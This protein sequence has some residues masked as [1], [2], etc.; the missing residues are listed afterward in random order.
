LGGA[1]AL[2]GSVAGGNAST[3]SG[4][5]PGAGGSTVAA[6]GAAAG[7]AESVS[8]CGCGMTP[9][10]RWPSLLVPPLMLGLLWRRRSLRARS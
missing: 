7:P 9:K 4:G 5:A 8:G 10:Q 6:A 1:A 3:M 2:G